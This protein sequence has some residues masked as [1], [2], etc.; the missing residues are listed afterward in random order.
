MFQ[1]R[2]RRTDYELQ[3]LIKEQS[4][5]YSKRM[6]TRQRV[7]VENR[8]KKKP[9]EY[10]GRASNNKII[11]FKSK[12]NYIGHFIDVEITS[13]MKNIVYGE[14]INQDLEKEKHNRRA[15]VAK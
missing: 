12:E 14:I 1:W 6:V 13:V 8:F 3:S 10:F 7:L 2:L 11:N 5:S 9:S 4:I 15:A